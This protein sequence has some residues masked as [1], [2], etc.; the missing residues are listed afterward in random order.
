M[1]V[2]KTALCQV[3]QRPVPAV[4]LLRS[5]TQQQQGT[6]WL[7]TDMAFLTHISVLYLASRGVSEKWCCVGLFPPCS[8]PLHCHY[9]GPFSFSSSGVGRPQT[10]IHMCLYG[11]GDVS[12]AWSGL[13]HWPRRSPA[14]WAKSTR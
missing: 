14:C 7:E 10:D 2:L 12:C 3:G 8:T 11:P 4:L 1:A 6:Q 9:G 5:C 13:S